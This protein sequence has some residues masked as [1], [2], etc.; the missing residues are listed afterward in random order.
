MR[1]IGEKFRVGGLRE[2]TK[3]LQNVA[4]ATSAQL[5]QL[6]LETPAV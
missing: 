6:T 4:V 3:V 5:F 1:H 2:C